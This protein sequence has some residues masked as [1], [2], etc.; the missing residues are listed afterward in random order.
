[1]FNRCFR[2]RDLLNLLLWLYSFNICFRG[3]I[4]MTN[5]RVWSVSF[6]TCCCCCYLWWGILLFILPK[7]ELNYWDQKPNAIEKKKK[8]WILEDHFLTDKVNI[9]V[10]SENSLWWKS[11]QEAV[12]YARLVML[13]PS[14]ITI[15]YKAD[16]RCWHLSIDS[17]H[18]TIHS[19]VTFFSRTCD[20]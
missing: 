14:P 5:S 13:A 10:L 19:L 7:W 1:M 11:N 12:W 9:L 4:T 8:K 16:S 15:S 6:D 3:I 17:L 2:C 20:S 18:D